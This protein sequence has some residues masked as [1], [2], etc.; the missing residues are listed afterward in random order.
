SGH[1]RYEVSSSGQVLERGLFDASVW[2]TN[3]IDFAGGA[4]CDEPLEQHRGVP[5]LIQGAQR[6]VNS[7]LAVLDPPDEIVKA[8]DHHKSVARNAVAAESARKREAWKQDRAESIKITNPAL[9]QDA[10]TKMVDLAVDHDHRRL[11]GAWP[12]IVVDD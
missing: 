9:T 6:L 11:M 8:A 10:I 4:L 3:R 7:P 12:I 5:L 2:Q 1:G